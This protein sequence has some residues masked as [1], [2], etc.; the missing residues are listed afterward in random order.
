M[1]IVAVI[2]SVNFAA[3]SDDDEDIDTNQ[4]EGTWGMVHAEG[5]FHNEGENFPFNE[6]FDPTNPIEDYEKMVISKESDNIYSVVNYVYHN[7]QWVMEDTDRFTLDGTTIFPVDS[8]ND[9]PSS[10]KIVKV[11]SQE[12]VIESKGTDEYGEYY[13]K[14]TYK[15]L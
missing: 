4:L 10:M 13:D 7:N 9:G 5:Y 1:A 14:V 3:C 2:M 15:R 6:T 8:E 12:L 11:N